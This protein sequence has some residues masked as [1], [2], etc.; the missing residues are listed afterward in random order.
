MKDVSTSFCCMMLLSLQRSL[1]LIS[2]LPQTARYFLQASWNP[3]GR[4]SYLELF[5]SLW[6]EWKA[7]ISDDTVVYLYQ[8]SLSYTMVF[9]KLCF[10]SSVRFIACL[11]YTVRFTKNNKCSNTKHGTFSSLFQSLCNP[12]AFKKFSQSRGKL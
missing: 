8:K 4:L 9:S 7:S 10:L 3:M 11:I 1:L 2:I 12:A 5:L 6:E